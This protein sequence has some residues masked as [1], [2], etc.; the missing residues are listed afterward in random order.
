M[1][2]LPKRDVADGLKSKWKDENVLNTQFFKGGRKELLKRRGASAF[3]CVDRWVVRSQTLK[4]G[5]WARGTSEGVGIMARHV[6]LS[7]LASAVSRK[8]DERW[9]G[10][11]D[12]EKTTD[13]DPIIHIRRRFAHE[14]EAT[15]LGA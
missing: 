7:V 3:T 6:Q 8:K 1:G 15:E 14:R 13:D 4:G 12:K 9:V 10:G 2:G 11:I 5:R